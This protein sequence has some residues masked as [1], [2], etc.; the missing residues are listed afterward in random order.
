MN[1]P[2]V[3]MKN[4]K[5]RSAMFLS[6]RNSAGGFTVVPPSAR[7]SLKCTDVRAHGLASPDA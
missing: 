7:S 5:K 2:K 6:G 4:A 1:I 3:P